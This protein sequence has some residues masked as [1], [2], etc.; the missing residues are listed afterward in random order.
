MFILIHLLTSGPHTRIEFKFTNTLTN[1]NI[2]LK[3]L[4]PLLPRVH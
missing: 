3:L 2:Y 4:N 1:F